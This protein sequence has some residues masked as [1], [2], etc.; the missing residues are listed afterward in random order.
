MNLNLILVGIN[1]RCGIIPNMRRI[2]TNISLSYI[3][4]ISFVNIISNVDKLFTN[5]YK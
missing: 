5:K 3:A 4:R 1:S 2:V